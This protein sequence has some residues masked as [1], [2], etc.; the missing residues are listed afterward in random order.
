MEVFAVQL[1][2]VGRNI[3][4]TEAIKDYVEKRLQKLKKY[5]PYVVDVHVVLY[6]QKINQTVEI[7]IL[8]NRFTIHG[9]ERSPD[10]YASIDMVIDKMDAQL[11]KYK[12]RLIQ[13]HQRQQRKE[14]ALKLNIS[15]FEREELEE[16]N[17]EPEVIHTQRLAIKPMSVDEAVMQMDLI[18][19]DFLVF[20]NAASDGVNVLYRRKD[21]QYGLIEPE[22]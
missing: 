22:L 20:R 11:K 10:L 5:F 7:T 19:Q 15:V 4:V 6:T 14:E 18:N 12:E 2:I 9:E 1:S 21:G 3:E 8:A 13:K 16:S 17:P